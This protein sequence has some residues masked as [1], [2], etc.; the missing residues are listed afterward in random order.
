M[1]L[2][3]GRL[4]IWRNALD[5]RDWVGGPG[6]PYEPPAVEGP[7]VVSG[8]PPSHPE[9]YR[10]FAAALGGGEPLVA[11]GRSALPE[12]ELANALLLSGRLGRE[13]TLPLDRGQVE[14][15]LAGA[16]RSG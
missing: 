16:P 13:V 12:V 4:E 1:R 5:M 3:P 11:S 6:D 7:Q 8:E 2:R 15:E 14:R 10:N 9:L